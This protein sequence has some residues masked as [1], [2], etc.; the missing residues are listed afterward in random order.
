MKTICIVDGY[1]TGADLAPEFRKL[2][3]EVIHVQSSPEILPDFVSSYRPA[4]YEARFVHDGSPAGLEGLARDVAPLRP[5]YVVAGTETGVA[6]ADALAAALGLPGNDP[7]TTAL[8]RDKYAMQ[9][10]LRANGLGCIRQCRV[11]EVE[12][13]AEW[14]SALGRWPLVVKPIDSAG[15]DG[16]FF[17]GS[18][19]EVRAAVRALLGRRNRLGL[20]NDHVLIQERIFGQQYFVNAVTLG[21][22]HVFTE[23]WKDDKVLVPGAGLI[24]DR[25]ELLPYEGERQRTILDYMGK[26]LDALGVREGPSHSELMMTE[27]GPVLIESAARM[28]GTILHEAVVAALGDSHVTCTVERY[29]D[30]DRFAGRLSS[31]YALRSNLHCVT[32][33]SAV[34]GT[35][36]RNRSLELIG[37]LPSY[38]QMFHTPGPG[39]RIER[40]ID[41][42]SNPGIVYLLHE[43]G[44]RLEADYAR[45]RDW[46]RSGALFEVDLDA[47]RKA[48]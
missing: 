14:A 13:A 22:R 28:Q 16:V 37:S 23:I 45:I 46:E 41:L 29:A 21:G 44:A 39:E 4:D 20:E 26:V 48:G 1:S 31:P 9:E 36:R 30:P 43:D 5:S 7:R 42:F 15:A 25:E 17:C 35:V 10:A 2:G 11:S 27:D 24:C 6:L 19:A 47:D 12:A 40:T 8:R 32:L 33:A 18:V 34:S 3:W 38:F